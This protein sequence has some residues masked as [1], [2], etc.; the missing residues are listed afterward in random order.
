VGPLVN[1]LNAEFSRADIHNFGLPAG[2]NPD[3]NA[4]ALGEFDPVSV[5]DMEGFQLVALVIQD[6]RAIGQ[7]AVDIEQE[8][9]NLFRF[10]L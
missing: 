9:F 8:E 2:D 3:R 6:D 1:F 4:R 5:P 7:N 10:R